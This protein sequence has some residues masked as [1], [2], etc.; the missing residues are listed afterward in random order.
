M[1]KLERTLSTAYPT[2]TKYGTHTDCGSNNKQRINNY[3]TTALE[4][5]TDNYR[6]TALEQ[7][8]TE[9]PP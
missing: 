6:T 1:A 8:T 5:R 9:P 4:H 3:R 2:W 7:K